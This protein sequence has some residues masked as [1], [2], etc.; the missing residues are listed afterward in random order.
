MH[1]L[2]DSGPGDEAYVEVDTLR[3][4]VAKLLFRQLHA[5]GPECIFHSPIQ[6]GGSQLGQIIRN[7]NIPHL[8]DATRIFLD[9]NTVYK[10]LHV[11][12]QQL[13]DLSTSAWSTLHTTTP[14]VQAE[15][16]FETL[17]AVCTGHYASN[18]KQPRNDSILF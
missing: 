11:P 7:Y 12:D 8:L 6:A 9:T 2:H 13:L 1:A 16:P 10:Q 14:S 15:E 3:F 4:P 18:R 17:K 5:A